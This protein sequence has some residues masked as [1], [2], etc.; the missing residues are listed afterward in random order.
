MVKRTLTFSG[1]TAYMENLNDE[2]P[3]L[4]VK[5][6]NTKTDDRAS[7]IIWTTAI[8]SMLSAM[9]FPFSVIFVINK[10]AIENS[11]YETSNIK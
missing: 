8:V 7:T 4:T 5:T 11:W 9:L 2:G 1:L 10:A 6:D 3:L